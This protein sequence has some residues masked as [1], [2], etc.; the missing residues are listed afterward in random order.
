MPRRL[1]S[2]SSLS[3]RIAYRESEGVGGNIGVFGLNATA[4]TG[5]LS[6]SRQL[7][8]AT[9]L[10]LAWRSIEQS[11]DFA[12]NEFAENRITLNIR[13]NFR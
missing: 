8:D 11:S 7:S 2:Q 6:L 13:H 4:W 3:A 1:S 5:G 12:F 9:S 10:S